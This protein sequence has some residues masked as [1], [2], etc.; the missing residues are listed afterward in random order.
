LAVASNASTSTRYGV[1]TVRGTQVQVSQ[2]G[3]CP[4]FPSETI[5]MG[6]GRVTD[7]RTVDVP[8]P[9]CLPDTQ[10]SSNVDWL[11]AMAAGGA[12]KLRL[13]A[14]PNFTGTSRTGV[15]TLGQRTLTVHQRPAGRSLDFN[16]DGTCC[17]ITGQR[18]GLVRG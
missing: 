11:H 8:R 14:E 18:A 5:V 4:V 2:Y 17:G 16:N 10:I 1:V 6:A 13:W 12:L 9:G 7:L 3:A 15:V